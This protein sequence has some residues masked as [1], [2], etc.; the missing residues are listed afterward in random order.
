MTNPQKDPRLHL[1]FLY[2]TP[3]QAKGII[4]EIEELE[5]VTKMLGWRKGDHKFLSALKTKLQKELDK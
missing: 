2:I 5:S 3:R 4:A 1:G